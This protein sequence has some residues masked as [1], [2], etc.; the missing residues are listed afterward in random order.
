[1]ALDE[2]EKVS[3]WHAVANPVNDKGCDAPAEPMDTVGQRHADQE[4]RRMFH[5]GGNPNDR[6]LSPPVRERLCATAISGAKCPKW[7]SGAAKRRVS[8]SSPLHPRK[9]T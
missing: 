5:S 3:P 7:V 9:L 1:M 6:T 8:I 4:D 2:M